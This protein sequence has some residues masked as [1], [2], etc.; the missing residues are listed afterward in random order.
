MSDISFAPLPSLSEEQKESFA[1]E[2]VE[3]PKETEEFPLL[4][5]AE[6][7]DAEAEIEQA[8][9]QMHDPQESAARVKAAKV[10][11]HKY[12]LSL[13]QA[14]QM[15]PKIAEME[16]IKPIDDGRLAI[17][18]FWRELELANLLA[19]VAPLYNKY[20]ENQSPELL[21]QINELET[22]I[23][24]YTDLDEKGPLIEQLFRGPATQLPR[25]LR[26]A[27]YGARI[28]LW[29]SVGAMATT[30]IIGQAIPAPEETITV[31]LVGAVVSGTV[32][33][34]GF[35]LGMKVGTLLELRQFSAGL[36]Y[37]NLITWQDENGR[38]LDHGTAIVASELI[39]LTEAATEWWQFQTVLGSLGG[40]AIQGT[41]Y[42]ALGN[43]IRSSR[44]AEIATRYVGA[45]GA[46]VLQEEV[47]DLAR[48]LIEETTKEFSNQLQ[49]TEFEHRT[50]EDMGKELLE[51]LTTTPLV[52]ALP[53][54]PQAFRTRTAVRPGG[55]TEAPAERVEGEQTWESVPQ[56]SQ[57][58]THVFMESEIARLREEI[59]A[60]DGEVT[61]ENR[62]ALKEIQYYNRDQ[63][64]IPAEEQ[65]Q[66]KKTAA[67]TGETPEMFLTGG[68]AGAGKSGAMGEFF[69]LSRV[70][71]VNP[72]NIREDAGQLD[73][74]WHESGASPIAEEL[75]NE[76]REKGYHILY[77]SQLTNLP[78]AIEAID[79]ALEQGSQAHIGFTWITA[80]T[81]VIRA[82]AREL[83]FDKRNVPIE[84]SAKGWNRSFATFMELR[85]RYADNPNV[86]FS[87]VDN[88]TDDISGDSAVSI[89]QNNKVL[90]PERLAELED[91]GYTI[92]GEGKNA[93]A[94]RDQETRVEAGTL[95]AQKESLY[96]RA[97]AT[98]RALEAE[99]REHPK[100]REL[101]E[102]TEQKA[103][104]QEERQ[105][106]EEAGIPVGERVIPEKELARIENLDQ[107][108]E[109]GLDEFVEA[110]TREKAKNDPLYAGEFTKEQWNPR[111]LS[112][113]LRGIFNYQLRETSRK[114]E[115]RK[116]RVYTKA[117]FHGRVSAYIQAV[118]KG[119][120]LDEKQ[121]LDALKY[122][123]TNPNFYKIFYLEATDQLN[124]ET[125]LS[126][127]Y[128]ENGE[129]VEELYDEARLLAE[130]WER[131]KDE[132]QRTE[133]KAQAPGKLTDLRTAIGRRIKED[134]QKI[135]ERM[136]TK[137]T[138]KG[139]TQEAAIIPAQARDA[140]KKAFT[141]GKREGEAITKIFNQLKQLRRRVRKEARERYK[142]VKA[143]LQKAKK[144]TAT[145]SEANKK[146]ILDLLENIELADHQQKT[147]AKLEAT[148]EYL[149]NNPDADMPDY[150]IEKLR[151]LDKKPISSFTVEELEDIHRAVMHH[152]FLEKQKQKIRI[153][154]SDR[155]FKST[156][157]AILG[158]LKEIPESKTIS[159]KPPGK[160]ETVIR[161]GRE[162]FGL[163]HNH[164]D[165]MI[166]KI[167]GIN[168]TFYKLFAT[169][170]FDAVNIKR[171]HYQKALKKFRKMVDDAGV[172]R[173]DWAKWLDERRTIKDLQRE[174]TIDLTKGEIMALYRHSLNEDN[175]ASVVDAGF[176]FKHSN[177]P[178]TW[179]RVSEK[180]LN[181]ILNTMTPQELAFANDPVSAL[182]KDQG[183]AYQEV[184][185][186]IHGYEM[187]LEDFYYHKDTMPVGRG[188]E[189]AVDVQ[190]EQALD[191][192]R[193]KTLRPGV[194]KGQLEKRRRVTVPIYLNNIAY[195]INRSIFDAANYIGLE[196]TLRAVS[197][198]FYNRKFRGRFVDAYGEAYYKEIEQS[199]RDIAGE[200][201]GYHGADAFLLKQKNRMS[202]AILGLEPFIMLKQPLSYAG[203]WQYVDAK[204]LAQGAANW[205]LH[206]KLIEERHSAWSPQ[207]ID[208]IEK[209]F[210]RD[211]RDVLAQGK[212]VKKLL[213]ASM[214]LPEAAMKPIQFAD[215]Q[216]VGAVMESAVLQVLD[217][218]R[219]GKLSREVKRAL[220]I[221]EA[222]VKKMD[223]DE[224]MRQ[225]YR[226][227]DFVVV[228]TQPTFSPE[229]QAPIQRG[230]PLEK[231]I[232]MF[233]SYTNQALN[234]L[235]RANEGI[236]QNPND[237]GAWA[238]AAKA[239]FAVTVLN[240]VG[241][242]GIN[243]LRRMLYDWFRGKKR[244][245]RETFF[246]TLL[247]TV[248]G[249]FYGMRD[250]V[251]TAINVIQYG[252]FSGFDINLPIERLPTEI[253]KS[254]YYGYKGITKGDMDDIGTM[255]ESGLRAIFMGVG[256]PFLMPI[257]VGKKLI[258]WGE[259]I[260]EDIDYEK[261]LEL[262]KQKR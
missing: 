244:K 11:A 145:M 43:V 155:D 93:R 73:T 210:S 165:L 251:N 229:Y 150:M 146:P 202:T 9:L 174:G 118:K 162:F 246:I 190:Q 253:V 116:Y 45:I 110:D 117:G 66:P 6:P 69:D 28:G 125:L 148:A 170:V 213:G 20:K 238:G 152:V 204:H 196:K 167:S 29:Y 87:L 182:F 68:P 58:D 7:L 74:E 77:D 194:N 191:R 249:F 206:H 99:Q 33:I 239:Y 172:K 82:R 65:W 97:D 39:G 113:F 32:G 199:L 223:A 179:Y 255:I 219:V 25:W 222:D 51:T 209:G 56:A 129:Q 15:Y 104:S 134:M 138:I 2:P 70:V 44:F 12:G 34:A 36:A 47:Q 178:N 139:I 173:N 111:E 156:L 96:A 230:T 254:I 261:R 147:I 252:P 225:A 53:V 248:S 143:D 46:E 136:A 161:K 24:G 23:A 157:D 75:F 137:R 40:K 242:F 85:K 240:P 227:A 79:W 135:V 71:E 245:D 212:E 124:Q 102:P 168:S 98:V 224:K 169:D 188:S 21:E 228:R 121:Y 166:E 193:G 232:T 108:I 195:D 107:L 88:E 64:K 259:E 201:K 5:G 185:A 54:L 235:R 91:F 52:F 123:N 67:E 101:A 233:S 1:P 220:D 22:K 72:D 158:E 106:E 127:G 80:E 55:I 163:R 171:E 197:K 81:S 203:A 31:P 181:K 183:Q 180:D 200:Y 262:R 189:F 49:G 109:E 257:R 61:P 226:F 236:R 8:T 26:A 92:I 60:V 120:T 237:P 105:A 241:I 50:L 115:G 153:R 177:T 17:I 154:L 37:R 149:D 100:P 42:K 144:A 128:D 133:F 16:G 18:R 207:W 132:V 218:F 208:R 142:G 38:K 78:R 175:H 205:A 14:Y 19:D 95:E 63:R 187:Q 3:P 84:V 211:V 114:G 258:D 59:T 198:V 83:A 62:E 215:K 48:L 216:T 256:I 192:F 160:I 94:E 159:S 130:K 4:R 151:M 35:K 126:L 234:M 247:R 164:Y 90:D 122:L 76:A 41:V 184:W 260:Y 112:E 140:A 13:N 57:E 214:S 27:A 119:G 243:R 131:I 176:G 10:Y 141:Q 217:E 250:V 103:I 221:T 186:D 30:A 89:I 231:M 86:T